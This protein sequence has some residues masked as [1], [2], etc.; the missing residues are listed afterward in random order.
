MFVLSGLIFKALAIS[1]AILTLA[2]WVSGLMFKLTLPSLWVRLAIVIPAELLFS[3]VLK[4]SEMSWKDHFVVPDFN[5]A[6]KVRLA[7][8]LV[9]CNETGMLFPTRP[10]FELVDYDVPAIDTLVNEWVI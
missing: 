9:S 8:P 6:Y 3:S 4:A 10:D 1:S 5:F 2:S 7:L